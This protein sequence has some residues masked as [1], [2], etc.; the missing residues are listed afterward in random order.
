MQLIE[1]EIR[2]YDKR[3]CL[4]PPDNKDE[5]KTKE[6]DSAVIRT[7]RKLGPDPNEWIGSNTTSL[8][9]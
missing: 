1:K 6:Q 7:C 2:K 8:T 4:V 9:P 3:S 5:K